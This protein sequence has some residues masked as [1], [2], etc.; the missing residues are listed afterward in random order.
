V[1]RGVVLKFC[2]DGR[3]TAAGFWQRRRGRGGVFI[4]GENLEWGLGFGSEW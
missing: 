1:L 3:R 4:E 2:H